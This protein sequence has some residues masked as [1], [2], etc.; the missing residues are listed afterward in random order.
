MSLEYERAS[1]QRNHEETKEALEA[2]R[3][4]VEEGE[5]ARVADRRDRTPLFRLLYSRCTS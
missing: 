5:E 1:E 4:R 3:R 2:L